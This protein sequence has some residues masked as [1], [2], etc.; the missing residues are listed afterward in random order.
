MNESKV[1]RR[2]AALEQEA[3]NANSMN[4][5]LKSVTMASCFYYYKGNL[6][7]NHLFQRTAKGCDT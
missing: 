5:A 1:K 4:K 3:G 7:P 2:S 6:L